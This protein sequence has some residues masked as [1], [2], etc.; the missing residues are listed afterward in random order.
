MHLQ[1]NEEFK[2]ILKNEKIVYVFGSGI[3]SALANSP[4]NWM[5]WIEKGIDFILDKQLA[6]KLKEKLENNKSTDALIFTVGKVINET[7]KDKTYTDWM[8]ATIE[9]LKVENV[10]L[11]ETLSLIKIT[12]DIITTTNYDELLEMAMGLN[13]ISYEEPDKAFYML[14]NGKAN[15]VLHL[16]GLYNSEKNIDNII[17]TKNQYDSI[18]NDEAAQFIQQL[19]GTRTLIFIGAGQTTEDMNI[20]RFIKF[21]DKKLKIDKPYVYIKRSTEEEPKLPENFIVIDYGDNYEDLPVFLHKMINYRISEFLR[22]TPIIGR[23]VLDKNKSDGY[24]LG[25]YHFSQEIIPFSGR[26]K[27]LSKLK[28]FAE[29]D[30]QILWWA[31]NGQGGS[32]KSRLAY[33]FIKK[34]DND[35][36]S[37]FLNFA[38]NDDELNSFLPFTDTFIVIDYVK[39]N[40]NKL[41]KII[42]RL[43][44]KYKQSPYKLRILMLER[45]NETGTGSWY[46][47]LLENMEV[48][49]RGDFE[50]YEYLKDKVFNKHNFLHLVDLEELAVEE[51]IGSICKQKGLPG[52]KGRNTKLRESYFNKFERLRYRPLFIQIYIESW[53]DNGGREVLYDG[54]E[55]L[56]QATIEKEQERWLTITNNNILATEALIS[57]IIRASIVGG[58]KVE[59]IPEDYKERWKIVKENFSLGTLPG[60]Q[61]KEKIRRNIAETMSSTEEI[62]NYINP[63]YPDIIKEYMFLYYTDEDEMKKVCKELWK[64]A[65]SQFGSFLER[66]AMDFPDNKILEKII[67]D[68][69]LDLENNHGLKARLALL[70]QET[71]RT[72]DEGIRI[73]QILTE[74]YEFWKSIDWDKS[75][76]KDCKETILTGLY[77]SSVKLRG[78]QNLDESIQA[79]HILISYAEDESISEY[80]Y[81][82]VIDR[83]TTLTD[84]KAYKYSEKIYEKIKIINVESNGWEKLIK[85]RALRNHAVN[86]RAMKK[87]NKAEKILKKIEN[88]ID[89]KDINQLEIY[90]NTIYSLAK[91]EYI[92]LYSNNL[93]SYSHELEDIMICVF[94]NSSEYQVNDTIHYYYLYTKFLT[95][96]R[97]SMITGLNNEYNMKDYTLGLVD[98]LISEIERNEMI[99][100]FAGIYVGSWGLKVAY[101]EKIT[102]FQTDDYIERA[103]IF[104]NEYVDNEFLCEKTIV[105]V[106]SAYLEQYKKL[107][108]REILGRCYSLLL[109]FP[110]NND[111]ITEFF[112]L[113]KQANLTFTEYKKRYLRSKVVVDG[114]I[115]NRREDILYP[116]YTDLDINTTYVRKNPKIGANELCPCGSG[117]KFKKCCR[118]NG[119]YD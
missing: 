106:S 2:K 50:K 87:K 88:L 86:N 119:K 100:E 108:T 115:S 94:E 90:T 89:W 14:D 33:E 97:L 70:Q 10:S 65:P 98:H 105:L 17:A 92:D 93:L 5:T 48:Y 52:D 47:N 13:S 26:I 19:L 23:T 101:D 31:I 35:Y 61:R 46:G 117:K 15:Y 18:Y 60:V 73:R 116:D 37:F 85:L 95:V 41:S 53:I 79:I 83:M 82:L 44:Y 42:K 74:E 104:C 36:Y 59:S 54:Y 20:S 81:N 39:G 1:V 56:L 102:D 64:N 68:A 4:L 66:C 8:Q 57:I 103:F 16:H 43:V 27:E 9:G 12:R 55:S 91:L 29:T 49:D 84:E 113:V 69:S 118:G 80:A 22:K 111:V 6:K 71:I 107:P 38:I 112:S 114:L 25:E 3:S 96:D 45:S 109:R 28:T 32:G 58:F 62:E 77:L 7:K 40:E 11:A 63:Q 30:K 24:G 75:L 99:N 78:W 34:I 51:L 21:A 110:A 72:I 67:K 76:S